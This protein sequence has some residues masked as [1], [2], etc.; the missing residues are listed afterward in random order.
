MRLRDE[1]AS[2]TSEAPY[3]SLGA[4]KADY[5]VWCDTA[6]DASQDA[7]LPAAAG[8]G[9]GAGAGG[10]SSAT[11]TTR[12]DSSEIVGDRLLLAVGEAKA[13]THED[14]F[15]WFVPVSHLCA[16]MRTRVCAAAVA[17][18]GR[19]SRCCPSPK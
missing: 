10:S 15:D 4:L 19:R 8:A 5:L 14:S 3:Y 12:G 11:H 13:P 6:G 2:A 18:A 7:A 16:H 1:V 17:S 9:A